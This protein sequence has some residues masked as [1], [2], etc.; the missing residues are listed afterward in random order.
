VL[1]LFIAEIHDLPKKKKKNKTKQQKSNVYWTELF[2]RVQK[3]TFRE[4][5]F[6][7]ALKKISSSELLVRILLRFGT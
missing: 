3:K 4:I 6:A 7:T 5:D 2:I 1:D